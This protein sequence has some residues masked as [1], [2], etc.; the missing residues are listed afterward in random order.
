MLEHENSEQS[1]IERPRGHLSSNLCSTLYSFI[2]SLSSKKNNSRGELIEREEEIRVYENSPSRETFGHQEQPV[3]LGTRYEEQVVTEIRQETPRVNQRIT[4][5]NNE[6]TDRINGL[7]TDQPNHQYDIR[8][9]EIM[10]DI[11]NNAGGATYAIEKL[12]LNENFNNDNVQELGLTHPEN[13]ERH[14]DTDAKPVSNMPFFRAL[15]SARVLESGGIQ[16]GDSYCK[17]DGQQDLRGRQIWNGIQNI[18]NGDREFDNQFTFSKKSEA[19]EESPVESSEPQTV[20]TSEQGRETSSLE[21]E[22]K[23]MNSV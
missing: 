8:S 6:Y 21:R 16:L 12:H 20:Q 3:S 15:E 1:E 5:Q 23:C 2:G 7:F 14:T 18:V 13:I 10:D 17:K 4:F 22:Y 19:T 11:H 9:R